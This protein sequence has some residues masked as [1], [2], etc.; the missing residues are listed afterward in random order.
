MT[1]DHKGHITVNHTAAAHAG[2]M[3]ESMLQNTMQNRPDKDVASAGSDNL[4]QGMDML[5]QV[6]PWL[7]ANGAD[8]QK[9][10]ACTRET[11]QSRLPVSQGQG[12]S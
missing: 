4:I 5:Y 2:L 8:A 7:A 1:K 12:L 3:N 9:Q 10:I 6:G 11:D